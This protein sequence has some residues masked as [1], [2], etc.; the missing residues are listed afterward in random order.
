M[1]QS[2]KLDTATTPEGGEMTLFQH[3]TDYFIRINGEDLMGSRQHESELE[4]A[5]LGCAHLGMRREPRIL[6]G[7][8]GLG[9]TLSETLK[10]LSPQATIIVGELL[11]P[12]IAWNRKYFGE[13]NGHPLDD[14]RVKVKTGDVISLIAKSENQFDAI[15]LDIDNG[16]S[17]I[18]TSGNDRLYG[19]VGIEACK[20]ALRERGVLAVW[21]VESSKPYEDRLQKCGLH[22]RRHRV[23]AYPGSKSLSRFVW[24]ASENKGSLPPGGGELRNKRR[25]KSKKG[26]QKKSRR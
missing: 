18:S 10:M 8:L 2:I 25:S 19:P 24:V 5:R 11:K 20:N 4:L 9:F 12:M 14:P 22:V 26:T 13:L 21:S 16:P 7:G 3:D 23:A 1:K 17:A 15:L 6:I